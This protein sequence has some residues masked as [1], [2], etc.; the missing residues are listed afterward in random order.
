MALYY[1]DACIYLNLLKREVSK[2]GIDWTAIAQKFFEKA[3]Q[4]KSS[5]LYSDF[6]LKK[7][8]SKITEEE[9]K[10]KENDLEISFLFR[11]VELS[12]KEQEEVRDIELELDYELGFFDIIHLFLARREHAILVTR[13][14][15]L[16]EIAKK[17]HVEAM[18]P[19]EFLRVDKIH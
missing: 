13:D 17:Y 16:L 3:K 19:E 6:L 18:M 14:K 7:M 4:E 2:E 10:K 8:K 9:Y 15:K 1:V 11:K 12:K 5:V